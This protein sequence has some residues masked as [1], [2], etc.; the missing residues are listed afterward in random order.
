M[1]FE[2]TIQEFTLMMH[3]QAL[4]H[5]CV[6]VQQSD[7]ASRK[8]RFRLKTFDAKDYTIPYGATAVVCIIKSD[9][10]RVLNDC[11]IEDQSTVVVTLSTQSIACAGKQK[12]Q[13]YICADDGDIKSQGFFINVPRAV[14]SEDAVESTDEYGVLRRLIGEV[15]E[16]AKIAQDAAQIAEDA[17]EKAGDAVTAASSAKEESESASAYVKE[18]MSTV[19]ADVQAIKTEISKTGS[20]QVQN[21]NDAGGAQV[22]AVTDAGNEKLNEIEAAGSTQTGN[23]NN[24]GNSQVSA[25]NQA[26]TDAVTSI[27]E[28]GTKQEAIVKEAASGFATMKEDYMSWA[29]WFDLHRTGWHGGVK[30]TP[31]SSS[32]LGTKTG[33]NAELVLE[34]STNTAAGRNDYAGNLLFDGIV[35]NGYIDEDGEPH[36]TAVE[37]SPEFDRY[38]G[39]GDVWVA[40]LTGFYDPGKYASGDWDWRD[41]PAEGYIPEPHAV[42]PDGT[43]RSFYFISKYPGVV[44]ADGNVASISGKPVIRNASQNN[45]IDKIKPKG[46]QYCGL[47]SS[48]IFW[49]QWQYEMKYATRNSETY[50]RGCTAYTT[51]AP[52]TVEETGVKR[53]IISKTNANNFVIGSY[54]SIGH[55]YLNNGAIGLDRGNAAIHEI[56]DDVRITGIEEYDD[57]NSAV[58]VDV[59]EPFDTTSKVLSDD[60]VSPVYVSTMHWYSGSC[61]NVM[62]ADGSP[63]SVTSGKEPF[64]LSKVEMGHGGFVVVSDIILKAIYDSETDVFIQKPF[65]VDDSAKSAK[66]ITDDYTELDVTIPDTGNAWKYI[67]AEMS[68]PRYP[69]IQFPTGIAGSSST[70]YCDALH[71]GVRSSGLREWLWFGSLYD[72]SAAGLRCVDALDG[73]SAAWWSFLLRLSYLR[74]GVAA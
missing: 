3:G 68:D 54:I 33:D 14:Y 36:I 21:I 59:D 5:P 74:R 61:D 23:V 70:W 51:Q 73:V 48:D 24:A 72:W 57:A 40:F 39:N 16:D 7:T 2:G 46:T 45:Q 30:Y 42:R 25:V 53:V 12:A 63:S 69:H 15:E 37:G 22:K 8:V 28:E 58:Y 27:Q 64:I 32:P 50:A 31:G 19:D 49:F 6:E 11:T 66:T 1:A 60:L 62:G 20:A 26:G 41:T 29:Q 44:G 56:A 65:I 34:P 18:I 10:N 67:S 9:G 71:T 35:C 13:I 52:A 43:Y 47:T 55:G 17:M 38:G 4:E